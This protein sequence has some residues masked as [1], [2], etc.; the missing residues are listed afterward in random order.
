MLFS[1]LLIILLAAGGFALTYLVE[2]E[3]T[4]L[5]RAAAGTIIGSCI[6]GTLSFV[7]GCFAGLAV[8]S[9]IAILLTLAPLALFTNADRRKR[10]KLEWER[11]KNRMQGGSTVKF[12]KFSFYAFFFI[13]FCLF[14]SQAMYQTPQGIFTGGSNNLG[15]LPFHL[16]A[17]FGFTDGAN[18][19]P[20]NPSFAGAKFTYPFIADIVTAGFMKL[21]ADVRSA[22]V[23]QDIAW[24]FSL[25][26]LLERFVVKQT[27]DAFAGRIAPWLMF[28]SG[29]L[30]FIWFFQDYGS[31]GKGFFDFLQALPS[32]YTI[33]KGHAFCESLGCEFRWGNSLNTLFIT[34]RSLLLGMPLTV[35]VLQKLWDWFDSD[36][37]EKVKE[38]KSEKAGANVSHEVKK[39]DPN[40]FTFSHFPFSPFFVGLLAGLL[41]LVHLH[42]LAVLFIVTAFL[43]VIDSKQWQTWIAFGIGVAIIAIPELIW[44]MT[45]S[46]T[47]ASEFIGWNL[48]WDMPA[49]PVPDNQSGGSLLI[50]SPQISLWGIL[51]KFSGWIWF[52]FKN[53][54]F[55]IPLIAVGIYLYRRRQKSEPDSQQ[56]FLFYLPF[57]FC[58]L[59]SNVARLAPWQ[60]DNIKV[61]IYWYVGSLPFIAIALAWLWR[62]DKFLKLA[63][64]FCFIVLIL[65][66]ALDVYRVITGQIKTR[67]FDNDAIQIANQ[68]RQKTPP[69][70]LF[71][72][73]ATYNSAVVLS[74]RQS[75]MR[76]PGHLMSHG[77]DY[78]GRKKEVEAIYLGG[79]MADELLRKYNIDYVLISQEEKG[80]MTVNEEFFM[81]FPMVAQTATGRVYK[82]K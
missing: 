53:T 47:R 38:G 44:S 67:V 39:G 37:S 34:Q 27:G 19:P 62:K 52:W 36:S 17:I 33:G 55:V 8:A 50:L 56:L 26:I 21:G 74:G 2:R 7:I 11:A 82:I 80:A 16:G 76:Y 73:A 77:I 6:Y 3:E 63:A 22:M 42:S 68:I 18:L 25:L 54:G 41:P 66:G 24:A 23:V 20:V 61:L 13:V 10:F 43:L 65:A 12:L 72:N 35:V 49:T 81:K 9:P 78:Q 60:W 1:I 29:G 70:A 51:I 59:I 15:D 32:D 58:F 64:A 57:L 14:F 46:A 71:L 45:G 79:P 5:W 48:G 75:L 69:T 30:G 28:F 40:F 4:V 31:Q